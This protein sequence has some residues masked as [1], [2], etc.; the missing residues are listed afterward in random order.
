VQKLKKPFKKVL[1]LSKKFGII[2]TRNEESQT[3]LKK[4]K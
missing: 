1:T 4:G 3:P 2:N